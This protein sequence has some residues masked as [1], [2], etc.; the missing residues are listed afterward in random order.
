MLDRIIKLTPLAGALLIF[1]GVLKLIFFYS[2]FNI[3]IID[4]LEFQEIITSFFEDI[5]IIIFFGIIMTLISFVTLNF[6]GKKTRLSLDELI[7]NLLVIFYPKRFKFFF[8]F[9]AGIII[10]LCSIYSGIS[11]YNYFVIYLLTFFCIQMLTYLFLHKAESGEIN[12]PNFYGLLLLGISLTTSLYLLARH[13]IQVVE[14]INSNATIILDDGVI[15][16]NKQ[17]KNMY[18]GKTSKF[19]FVKMDSSHSTIA[20]PVEKVQYYI[21]K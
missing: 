13:D 11:G 17:T 21:F 9:L 19:V 20:I 3:R 10:T 15:D 12:I 6:L 5:N 4:Y 16:I 2:H 14:N 1:S 8:V 18:I 7:E